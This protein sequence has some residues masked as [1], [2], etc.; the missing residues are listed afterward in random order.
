LQTTSD[1][2]LSRAP[3]IVDADLLR[4]LVWIA[5]GV[6]AFLL[7]WDA[8]H[9]ALGANAVNFAIRTT[10]K[11]GLIFLVASLVVTPARRISGLADLIAMR[12]SLGL[13]GFA[14]IAT[15]FAIFFAYDRDGSIAGT[16]KEIVAR[17]YLQVGFLAL[18]LLVPLAIT[19]TDR[20][21]TRLGSKRWKQ[22]HRLAYVIVTLGCVHFALQVKSDL[23]QPIAFGVVAFAL[24]SYRGVAGVIDARARRARKRRFWSGE[25]RIVKAA[26]ETPDVRTLRLALPSGGPLPFSFAPGQYLNLTLS[27]GDR[28]VRRSYSISSSSKEKTYCEISVKRKEDGYASHHVHDALAEGQL[29]AVSGPAGRFVFDET[30]SDIVTL[31]GG[32]VGI[33]PLMSIVRSLVDARWRGRIEL[34][35]TMRT[36][37]DR[38]FAD[39]LERL[40]S[41]APGLHVTTTLTREKESDWKGRRGP[42]TKELLVEILGP[43]PR[44]PIYVCGPEA[45]MLAVQDALRELRVP[46]ADVWTE[47]FVSPG[48][49]SATTSAT[50]DDDRAHEVRFARQHLVVSAPGRLTL[51]E[52]A[53]DAGLDLPFECRSGICGRCKVKL[54]EGEVTMAAEDAL[55]QRDKLEGVVLSCQARAKTNIVVDA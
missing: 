25:L 8:L 20:M 11:L 3:K 1:P 37:R 35:L 10:G 24:L 45:M 21:Q 2:D 7:V 27:I 38:V 33:T 48:V 29:L 41:A 34:I 28:V 13:F 18:V 14:Y 44:G 49:A 9:G 17:F 30:S 51:L 42:I 32:G 4:W 12:R 5:G 23:R 19:S 31:I 16:A 22:L 52:A 50:E 6:P 26:L 36:S 40:A 43:E 39:E 55:S 46:D 53:E 15:H 54:L 47:A